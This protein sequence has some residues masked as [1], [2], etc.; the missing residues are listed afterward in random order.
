MR[1]KV[2]PQFGQFHRICWILV[3]RDTK[4]APSYVRAMSS[5]EPLPSDERAAEGEALAAQGLAIAAE[6]RELLAD[7]LAAVLA[8]EAELAALA[9]ES[10]QDAVEFL[11]RVGRLGREEGEALVRRAGG[12]TGPLLHG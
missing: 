7:A 1:G 11:V 6:A 5:G 4:R 2:T 8:D 3:T 10:A 9:P 12:G